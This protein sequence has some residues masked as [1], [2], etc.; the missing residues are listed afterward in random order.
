M[1]AEAT[2]EF[3][4][5]PYRFEIVPGGGHFLTDQF[6]DAMNTLLRSHLEG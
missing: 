4:K 6:P 1:A 2:G 3:V 5:G